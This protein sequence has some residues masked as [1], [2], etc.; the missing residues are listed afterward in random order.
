M[1]KKK[2]WLIVVVL[3]IIA[4]LIAS[5]I[6]YFK[7]KSSKNVQVFDENTIYEEQESEEIKDT[8]IKIYS[9][10]DRPIAVMIDN[11]GDA[12][13]QVGLNKAYSVYEIIVEGGLTRM[14]AL[15]KGQDVEMIGPVRSSRH[16]FLDYAM[17]NDAIYVH[18]GWSPQAESDISTYRINNINGIEESTSN[19]TRVSGKASPH[20]IITSTKAIKEIA[21]NKGYKIKSNAESVLHY[22]SNEVD[23]STRS[24]AKKLINLDIPYS[25][26]YSVSYKY[27]ENTKRYERYNG[28]VACKDWKTG[29]QIS[30]K[31]IIITFAQNINIEDGSGKGR[32]DLKDTG[33]LKGYYITN[34]YEIPITCTKK[35]RNE[36]TI[37]KDLD[38][39][40]IDVNDGNT[41]FEICPLDT[42]IVA[43]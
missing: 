2:T 36:K 39:K 19:F 17:E 11:V 24:D 7:I 33:T 31:N 16:Y 12:R 3:L 38:G 22:V 1:G 37:Y 29:E 14:M 35:S 18:Y 4:I 30:T 27:N 23:L 8:A 10:N 13:P 34:G 43:K 5:G 40:E 6:L 28:N 20:N 9:G 26:S 21:N 15:F 41:F 42:T 25:N 32:Q